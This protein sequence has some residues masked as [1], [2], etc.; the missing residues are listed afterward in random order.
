MSAILQPLNARHRGDR[1]FSVRLGRSRPCWAMLAFKIGAMLVPCMRTL[2]EELLIGVSTRLPSDPVIVST[3]PE[4]CGRL[5]LK[6]SRGG[7][8]LGG[9]RACRS[10]Q[11]LVLAHSF[12]SAAAPT[13]IALFCF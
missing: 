3:G 10:R 8:C 13:P 12:P 7:S 11:P 6:C 1:W 2:Q 4:V 5:G 9:R